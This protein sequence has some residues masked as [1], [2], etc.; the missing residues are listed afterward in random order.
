M[1]RIGRSAKRFGVTPR[2]LERLLLRYKEKGPA[3]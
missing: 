2:Q 1:I 3:G